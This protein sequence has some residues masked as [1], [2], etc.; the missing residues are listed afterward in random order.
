[1]TQIDLIG[2]MYTSKL[3]LHHFRRQYEHDSSRE[4]ALVLQGSIAG[5]VDVAGSPQYN[6]SKFALRGLL[7]SFRQTTHLHGTRVQYIAPW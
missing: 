4:T 2:V 7:H 3:A 5:Y 6:A 1:V